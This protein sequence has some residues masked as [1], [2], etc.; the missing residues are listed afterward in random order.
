MKKAVFVG[1]L[2]VFATPSFAQYYGSGQRGYGGYGSNTYGSGSNSS[3]HTVQPHITN[4]GTFVPGHQRTNPN[5]TQYDNYGTRGNVN[6]YTGQ[7]GTRT[8]RW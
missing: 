4:Q 6:P 2:V 3:S 7:Q 8:P 5:S 1:L